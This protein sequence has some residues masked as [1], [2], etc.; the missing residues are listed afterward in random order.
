MNRR[1]VSARAGVAGSTVTETDAVVVFRSHEQ[2]V[3]FAQLKPI[4]G[5]KIEATVRVAASLGM[6]T[7]AE[8]IETEAQAAVVREL[9]CDKGQGYLFSKPLPAGE[10]ARW[11]AAAA[12]NAETVEAAAEA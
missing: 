2:D 8:G 10:V 7:V 5:D 11:L 6:N 12:A 3:V 9:G 1:P 4:E